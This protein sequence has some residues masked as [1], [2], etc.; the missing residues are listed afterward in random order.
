MRSPAWL[1]LLFALRRYK[2]GILSFRQLCES[3]RFKAGGNMWASYLG[4]AL[5]QQ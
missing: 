1:V 3:A 2:R 4:Y 5:K